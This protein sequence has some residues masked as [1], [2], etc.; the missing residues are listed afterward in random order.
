MKKHF[1]ITLLFT[2]LF[3]NTFFGQTRLLWVGEETRSEDLPLVN[4][5]KSNG[6]TITAITGGEFT[7][8]DYASA[9]A[10]QN[11][12]AIYMSEIVGSSDLSNFKTAGFPIP[13]VTNKG[14]V[15]KFG[16]WD[17]VSD[18]DAYIF[19]PDPGTITDDIKTYV[20][21]NA[22]H[23]ITKVFSENQEVV[24]TTVA[25]KDNARSMGAKLGETIAGAIELATIKDSKY[26]GFPSLWAI[27]AGSKIKSNGTI[28]TAN[29]VWFATFSPAMAFV[30]DDLKTLVKRSLEWA[31]NGDVPSAIDENTIHLNTRVF[32]NPASGLVTVAFKGK[33]KTVVLSN[34]TGQKVAEYIPEG[35]I[36]TFETSN[37]DK[38]I[39]FITVKNE[40]VKLIVE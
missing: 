32:P 22:T 37:F 2:I 39:Y 9:D 4:F 7:A 10:Y 18:N 15:A 19:D 35:N 36:V 24:W 1:Y 12:D 14:H 33:A 6:Y 23:Y 31:I 21:K 38:G 13:C 30:T 3:C 16:K 17:L 28:F 8:V 25:D 27:P 20:I 26:T 5:L 11:Y 40:T 34:F 29:L